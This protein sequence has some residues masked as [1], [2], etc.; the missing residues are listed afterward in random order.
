M[1]VDNIDN[2]NYD[3][4]IIND[5]IKNSMIEESLFYKFLYSKEYVTF[6]GIFLLFKL[7]DIHYS[8]DK[9]IFDNIN[10]NNTKILNN[11]ID[12]ESKLFDIFNNKKKKIFKLKDIIINNNIKFNKS[13][14]DAYAYSENYNNFITNNS[15]YFILKLSGI[16][17][18]NDSYGITFKII[19]TSKKLFI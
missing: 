14:M 9:I 8:K 17:E 12:I 11:I 6:N 18:T 10:E 19:K 16:W 5:P 3:N 13:D 15:N 7:E 1:L 4:I 2:I